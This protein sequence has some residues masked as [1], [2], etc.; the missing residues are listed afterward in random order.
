[1]T[2]LAGTPFDDTEAR[3]ELALVEF[4]LMRTLVSRLSTLRQDLNREPL[5]C[6]A[7]YVVDNRASI[8]TFNYDDIVDEALFRVRRLGRESK[9]LKDT[10]PY[11]HPDGGY[12][13]FCRPS[14][15]SVEDSDI[16]QDRASTRL[17]K[18][19]G[20]VNWRYRLGE[21]TKLG[22]SAL[23]HHEEWSEN[24]TPTKQRDIETQL[25]KRPFIVPPVLSK[26]DLST[27]PVLGVVWR[28]AFATLRQASRV[29]FIGYSFPITDLASRS[30]IGE[31]L[32]REPSRLVE[33]VDFK[34]FPEGQTALKG[35]YRE[36]LG[37]LDDSKFHFGGAEERIAAEFSVPGTSVVAS[38]LPAADRNTK[39]RST[40]VNRAHRLRSRVRP[41]AAAT[42][43]SAW[44]P[45]P[46]APAGRRPAGARRSTPARPRRRSA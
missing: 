32:R 10:A 27:H 46:P 28:S 25:A 38:G 17:L 26:S 14:T 34:P 12:G 7:R 16:F 24:L 5:N 18:L 1:M 19:H 39:A 6:F 11:W 31:A 45:R 3:H 42:A 22:P 2:R 40:A 35:R 4:S 43:R 41:L 44:T 23:L 15:A 37:D 9:L 30:L 20:S 8:V 36:V 13:F 29:V 33:V 21:R